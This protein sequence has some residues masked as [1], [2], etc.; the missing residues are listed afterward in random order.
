MW[1]LSD[2][3]L[4]IKYIFYSYQKYSH[5]QHKHLQYVIRPVTYCKRMCWLWL[6]YW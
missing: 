2:C 4:I 3:H 6:Y 5:N 1:F